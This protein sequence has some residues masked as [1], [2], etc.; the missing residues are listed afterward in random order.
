VHRVALAGFAFLAS[1]LAKSNKFN[2]FRRILPLAGKLHSAYVPAMRAVG[3]Y[4]DSLYGCTAVMP[5]AV[6][7]KKRSLLPLLTFL[8]VISYALMTMLIVEQGAAIQSQ[9]NLIKVL[10]PESR[11]LWSMRGKALS[12]KQAPHAQAQGRSHVPSEQGPSSHAPSNQAPSNQAPSN[13]APS[14]QAQSNQA[15]Q[16]RSQKQTGKMAKP[17]EVPPAPASDLVDQR[18]ALHTI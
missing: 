2:V 14:N 9:R 6:P 18:R 7:K 13:Q 10:L 12:E 16:R 1:H 4:L 15:P 3:C 5:V 8:F 17:E 11:E